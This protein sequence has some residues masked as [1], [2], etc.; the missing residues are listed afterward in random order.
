MANWVG[1]DGS[2]RPCAR[3]G[4][5]CFSVQGLGA[6]VWS[7]VLGQLLPV[8]VSSASSF[9]NAA[10]G[11]WFNGGS[12]AGKFVSLPALLLG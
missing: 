12:K 4:C 10:E 1:M 7:V 3:V 8:V 5:G 11:C 9:F 6:F 2:N